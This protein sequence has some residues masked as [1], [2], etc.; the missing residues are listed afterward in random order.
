MAVVKVC[1]SLLVVL[2]SNYNSLWLAQS[3]DCW[4]NYPAAVNDTLLRTL[5]RVLPRNHPGYP[6]KR[7]FFSEEGVSLSL[8][9]APWKTLYIWKKGCFDYI[10]CS[11]IP[12]TNAVL[13]YAF[14][15]HTSYCGRFLV[16]C[17]AFLLLMNHFKQQLSLWL[18]TSSQHAL[19]AFNFFFIVS[20]C[21]WLF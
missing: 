16:T 3:H 12:M 7:T 14:P 2:L 19:V 10:T 21:L 15:S 9:R 5:D 8:C 6:R 13:N 1:G 20:G 11:W 17:P 4:N 18:M